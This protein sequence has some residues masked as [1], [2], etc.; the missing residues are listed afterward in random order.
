M[1]EK[2]KKKQSADQAKRI[3]RVKHDR[4][5]ILSRKSGFYLQE[6][7]RAL[8]TNVNFALADVNG[9]KVIEVT[10]SLESEGKSMTALNLAIAMGQADIKVLLIDCDLSRPRM[11][12]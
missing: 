6:A 12:R 9:C 7:Y 2:Q 3:S 10:S 5:F 8:R 4:K 1:T 11:A